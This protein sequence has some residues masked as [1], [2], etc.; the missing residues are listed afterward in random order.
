MTELKRQVDHLNE[1]ITSDRSLEAMELFYSNDVEMQ[2]NEDLP[3]KGKEL[4]IEVEK[5]NLQKMTSVH[6]TLL[7]QAIDEER[8]VVF[9][10]WQIQGMY[11]CDKKFL[12]IEVAV[13][14]WRGTQIIKEKFYYKNFQS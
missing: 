12:L 3:R 8:K 11:K 4:C 1:L 7:N 2:E 14:Q 10:E 5:L 6:Y 9:N 13:Q